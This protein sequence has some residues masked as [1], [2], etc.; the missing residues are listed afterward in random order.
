MTNRKRSEPAQ[1][2]S[3]NSR[4][5]NG[6]KCKNF[7]EN[8]CICFSLSHFLPVSVPEFLGEIAATQNAFGLSL[9][10]WR[11][12]QNFLCSKQCQLMCGWWPNFSWQYLEHR[13]FRSNLQGHNDKPKAFWA[14]T[15]HFQE[16]YN[17]KR[18]GNVT[19]KNKCMHFPKCLAWN[20]L[21][22]M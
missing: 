4:T 7:M 14:G 12:G 19:V 6:R 10:P 17:R 22:G 3:K 16:L 9:W 1:F 20:A 5:G 18:W 11:L 2:I 15:I 8:F 13:K 21:N